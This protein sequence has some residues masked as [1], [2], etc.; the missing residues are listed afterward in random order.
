MRIGYFFIVV[1]QEVVLL[2]KSNFL[3]ILTQETQKPGKAHCAFLISSAIPFFLSDRFLRASSILR[4]PSG[5]SLLACV[6]HYLAAG[7]NPVLNA[8]FL[9]TSDC[10]PANITL[11]CLQDSC[12]YIAA[13]LRSVCRMTSRS[14]RIHIL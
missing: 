2:P 14:S 12:S 9:S 1:C 4:T 3:S 10:E 11:E 6:L 8:Y 7:W 5:R 13:F